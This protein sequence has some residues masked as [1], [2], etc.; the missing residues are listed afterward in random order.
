M[1]VLSIASVVQIESVQEAGE[2]SFKK[3]A[4]FGCIGL[5]ASL[6]LMTFGVDLGSVLGL[7]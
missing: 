7:V 6:C 1:T 4:L 2:Y 3:I 5:M